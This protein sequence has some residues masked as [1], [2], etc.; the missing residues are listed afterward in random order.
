MN[1]KQT[2]LVRKSRLALSLVLA[3]S[4]SL[5]ATA[6]AEMVLEEILVTAQKRL[7]NLQD[8]P[9]TVSLMD[10]EK[11]AEAGI[12]SLEELTAYMPNFYQTKTPTANIIY[13]RGIG[14]GPNGGFEQSVA[15]FVDGIY[16]GRARQTVVP[17]MDMQRIEILKGPQ[18]ILFG[19]NAVAGAVN[20]VTNVPTDTFEGQ[21]SALLGEDGEQQFNAV[22]SGPLSDTVQARIALHDREIEGWIYNAYFDDDW[23][24][25][26]EQSVRLSLDWQASD[27][28][29]LLLK[30][31]R[32]EQSTGGTTPEVVKL[33][34]HASHLDTSDGT[35]NYRSNIGN[36]A[37]LNTRNSTDTD[38]DNVALNIKWELGN[39]LLTSV[40][41][42]SGYEYD[43]N[44][45]LDF[46]AA[47][48]IGV[49]SAEDYDQISQ[50]IRFESVGNE[51]F[52][53][54]LGG[55]YQEAELEIYSV[56]G[57]Q[58]STLPVETFGLLDGDRITDYQQDTDT[59]AV[60]AQVTWSITDDWRLTLGARYT[61]EEKTLQRE[62]KIQQFDGHIL[63]DSDPADGLALFLWEDRL[64]TVPYTVKRKRDESKTT[65]LITLQ[66]DLN[67]DVMLYGT[68]T[69]G[70]KGGGYDALYSNGK[71]VQDSNQ[72]VDGNSDLLEF[73]DE[74]ATN[75]EVGAKMRLLDG[76]AELNIA[77]F[78]TEFEDLQVSIF[79]GA[80]GFNVGNAAEA[81][82]Q[83]LELDGRFLA[84]ENIVLTG[85]VSYLDFEYDSYTNGQCTVD[86]IILLETGSES[87]CSYNTDDLP[88][89]DLTGQTNNYSPE[90]S[91]SVSAQYTAAITDGLELQTT[92]DL[93]YRDEYYLSSDLDNNLLA[94]ATTVINARVALLTTNESWQ[95]A[96]IGK[97]LTDEETV[98]TGEDV[99]FS[100]STTFYPT[101]VDGGYYN[102]V[103][104]PRSVA[105]EVKY[106]F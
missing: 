43:G 14:S 84:T 56:P 23:P 69:L 34:S 18:S 51:T 83:G 59:M 82:S 106:R 3:I 29:E 79:D 60:F 99:P 36:V 33:P 57:F 39:H 101:A 80:A 25:V 85:S 46:T 17:L 12:G 6:N 105:V 41:G 27:T 65:P 104:R 8:V 4:A 20:M 7:E 54:I 50:E 92:V 78:R 11:L 5:A 66:H 42:Y 31:E 76:R 30:V 91:A 58:I 2:L 100:A 73:E 47:N 72:Y 88:V 71:F 32:S 15:M 89:R 93:N 48:V 55:Y 68:W 62:V 49:H 1:D 21:V 75:I 26:D 86:Q 74:Q 90:W 81:T 53:Y 24:V 22:F 70:Y 61:D 52:N 94:D 28:L 45:D 9:V 44:G 64:K 96:L 77:Y 16:W 10:G 97:N 38:I 35:L 40:T 37:P 95:V 103:N 19:K 13:I 102:Y 67:D 98:S 63:D 87:N